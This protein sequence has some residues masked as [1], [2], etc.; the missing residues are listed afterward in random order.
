MRKIELLVA[1]S[2]GAIPVLLAVTVAPLAATCA[3]PLPAGT[4]ASS[5]GSGGNAGAG[6]M[7]V[8]GMNVGGDGGISLV[9]SSAS[10][11]SGGPGSCDFGQ[12]TMF[13]VQVPPE[14]T[15]ADPG[16]ICAVAMD[17][18]TSNLAARVTLQKSP[19][20]DH[21]ATGFVAID[22]ALQADI[23]GTP[24]IKVTSPDPKLAAVQITN[25]MA[26]AGGFSFDAEWPQPFNVSP[27]SWEQMTVDVTVSLRCDPQAMTIRVIQSTTYINLCTDMDQ[28]T[29][30]SSG[31]V[32]NACDIIAEMAP[33]PIV[34]DKQSDHLPLGRAMR[35]RVVPVARIGASVVL[36]AENDG[37]AGLEYTWHPSAGKLE[38]IT[39]DIAVWTPPSDLLPHILQVAVHGDDAAAVATYGWREP[40]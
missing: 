39:D 23:I 4:A 15:P 2:K 30:V 25:I 16:Q 6:G 29:W 40:S 22:P 38:R 33:S 13:T 11:S 37:G 35:L 27:H 34:P 3:A 9:T 1:A 19:M 24:T 21:L 7:N 12:K 28:L 14:G 5:V 8:G 20:A 31:E 18:V 17:P 32:C 10:S 36:F 26:A